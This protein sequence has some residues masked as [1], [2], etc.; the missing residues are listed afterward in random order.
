[1]SAIQAAAVLSFLST[2]GVNVH[3]EYADE[4]ANVAATE[5]ALSYLG[6]DLIRDNVLNPATALP[7][8]EALAAAGIK[9][10]LIVPSYAT[11]ASSLTNFMS[12]V[13]TLE[14][15]HPGCIVAFEGPNET[16]VQGFSFNGGS[17]Q[18]DAIAYQTALFNAVQADAALAGIG[19]Y[20]LSIGSGTPSVFTKYGNLSAIA[21]HANSHAYVDVTSVPITGLGIL[22]PLAQEVTP[23]KPMVIT[24]TGY[25]TGVAN[26]Y[27]EIDEVGQAKLLLDTLCDAYMLGVARTYLY[28][29]FDDTPAFGYNGLGIYTSTGQPKE[30][31]TAIH[32]FTTIL[33]DPGA[34]TFT[35]GTLDYAVSIGIPNI[36][37]EKSNGHFELILWA[38]ASIWNPKTKKDIVAPTYNQVLTFGQVQNVQIYDPMVGTSPINT[39]S[40]VT[41]VTVPISDHPVVVDIVGTTPS[42]AHGG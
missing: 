13:D 32:N 18:A 11:G 28:S 19:V 36:L 15:T 24:E 22:L 41:S 9:L 5:L 39:Y 31:A 35:P 17:K 33:A 6:I 37:L 25:V 16:N 4:Y 20:Q 14:K 30:A 3:M 21:T 7:T 38:E 12:M 42:G 34:A 23:G 26:T 10:D 2:L 1:M 8:L 29:L 40:N 27:S